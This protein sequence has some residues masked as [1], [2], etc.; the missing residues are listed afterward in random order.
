MKTLTVTLKQHTPL[1]HFQHDQYG[2]TLRASEVKP[3][4]DKFLLEKLGGSYEEGIESARRK[5]W[6]VEKKG[7]HPHPALDYKMRI[8]PIGKIKIWEINKLRSDKRKRTVYP[9]FFAN[10]KK[11]YNNPNDY[12]CFSFVEQLKMELLFMDGQLTNSKQTE[13]NQSLYEWIISNK[14][15]ARFFF[16]HNFGTRNSKGF[17][18]FYP[19]KADPEYVEFNDDNRPLFNSRY[20][21]HLKSDEANDE[22]RSL[23]LFNRIDLF[24]RSLRS[25]I[26]EIGKGKL[27]FKSLVQSYCEEKLNAKWEKDKIVDR[28]N[29]IQS[30]EICYYDIKDLLGFSTEEKWEAKYHATVKR[31]IAV[32]DGNGGWRMP[33]DEEIVKLP[34]RMKSPILFKPFYDQEKKEYIIYIRTLPTKVGYDDFLQNEKMGV[35]IN[36]NAPIFFDIPNES[37]LSIL[38]FAFSGNFDILQ[39]VKNTNSYSSKSYKQLKKIYDEIIKHRAKLKK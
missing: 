27:N 8:I 30:E 21:F 11:D 19:V 2:A 23:F 14:F 16:F 1:I 10:Q 33:T 12:K 22:M 26:N 15:L 38:D 5:G 34:Q 37:I 6:L 39:N 17:G 29:G 24:Y 7:E 32:E 35:K 18:S 13:E 31:T 28:L 4:L 3:K 25:G 9:L 20:F 36:D